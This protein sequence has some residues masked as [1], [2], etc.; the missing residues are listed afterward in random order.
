MNIDPVIEMHTSIKYERFI[1]IIQCTI[2]CNLPKSIN[3][4]IL[5]VRSK[6]EFY[7]NRNY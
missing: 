1:I 4:T 2:C 5:T 3:Y 7:K 6:T